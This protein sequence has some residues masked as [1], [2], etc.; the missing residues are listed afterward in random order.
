MRFLIDNALSPRVSE[1]LKKAG[2]DSVH[3]RDLGMQSAVDAV[4]FKT[5]AA[6][7]RILVSSDTDFGTL[8]AVKREAKPSCILFRRSSGNDP[9]KL[10]NIL[11]Q[12]AP[13]FSD[14][15]ER[16]AVI[17]F[18]DNRIRVRELPLF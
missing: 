10:L 3:L 5:A 13:K 6:E 18:T 11:L 4:V 7:D 9:V 1:G 17:V 14:E 16:G 15:L 12:Y 8:L 2:H